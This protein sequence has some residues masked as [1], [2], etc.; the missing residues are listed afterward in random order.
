MTTARRPPCPTAPPSDRLGTIH[1]LSTLLLYPD[2]CA[3][4]S[5][6][7]SGY[8]DPPPGPLQADGAP[9][10]AVGVTDGTPRSLIPRS[11]P[12]MALAQVSPAPLWGPRR[13]HRRRPGGGA[14][15]VLPISWSAVEQASQPAPRGLE[16]PLHLQ[17][18]GGHV[19][20]F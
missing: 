5:S 20:A 4:R 1:S 16:R 15:S 7:E 13:R 11:L 12:S 2:G 3:A 10:G 17:Q 6:D 9:R 18:V 14:P 8:R 19:L